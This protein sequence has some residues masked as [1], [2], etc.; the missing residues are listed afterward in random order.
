M[1]AIGV[2]YEIALF[3]SIWVKQEQRGV[4]NKTSNFVWKWRVVQLTHSEQR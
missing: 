4:R 3:L 2:G 1:H